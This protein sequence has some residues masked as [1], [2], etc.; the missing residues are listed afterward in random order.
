MRTSVCDGIGAFIVVES[1]PLLLG[2]EVFSLLESSWAYLAE[3]FPYRNPFEYHQTWR[4]RHF[5]IYTILSG[6]QSCIKVINLPYPFSLNVISFLMASTL[7]YALQSASS[8][9]PFVD[10]CQWKLTGL[11]VTVSSCL[12]L[13]TVS[14]S[15]IVNNH[16]FYPHLAVNFEINMYYFFNINNMMYYW[17]FT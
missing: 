14:L 10:T 8:K 16:Y 7:G 1:W 6:K 11:I 9:S 12:S 17:F 2:L 3:S 4:A 15:L 5:L 13:L